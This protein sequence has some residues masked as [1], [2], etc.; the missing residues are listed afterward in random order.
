MRRIFTDKEGQRLQTEKKQKN[1]GKEVKIQGTDEE[2]T[3]CFSIGFS[4]MRVGENTTK[5]VW[6]Y[7]VV[8]L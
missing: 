8:S 6:S 2:E 1:K 3:I 4:G 7:F 5:G